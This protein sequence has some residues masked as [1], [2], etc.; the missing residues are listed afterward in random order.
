[1]EQVREFRQHAD[2]CRAL[3][4]KQ[5]DAETRAQMLQLA[6]KWDRAAKEQERYLVP[7]GDDGPDAA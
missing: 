7:T 4:E 6:E 3:A 2:R 5:P 1:M